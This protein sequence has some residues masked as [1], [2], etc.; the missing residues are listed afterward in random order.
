MLGNITRVRRR[1]CRY[2]DQS[3]VISWLFRAVAPY[4]VAAGPPRRC[5]KDES[6]VNLARARMLISEWTKWVAVVKE[7]T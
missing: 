1:S 2:E 3:F 4:V 6:V 5:E 7:M